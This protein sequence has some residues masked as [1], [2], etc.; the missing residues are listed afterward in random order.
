MDLF[1]LI[2]SVKS[3]ENKRKIIQ[4]TH[5]SHITNFFSFFHSSSLAS[6]ME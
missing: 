3:K 4:Y 2:M 5:S 6:L 1:G